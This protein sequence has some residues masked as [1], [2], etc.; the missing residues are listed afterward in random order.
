[1][2]HLVADIG[3]TNSRFA[4]CEVGKTDLISPRK[5]PNKNFASLGDVIAQYLEDSAEDGTP[6]RACLAVAGPAHLDEVKLTNIDWQFSVSEYTK[7]YGFE[8]L[9]LTNDFTALAMSVP[10]LDKANYTCIGRGDAVRIEK[11]PIAVLGPGTGLG[12]S[13]LI[14]NGSSYTALQ[15][16][17]GNTSFA[18]TTDEEL[19]ILKIARLHI[20]H[21]RHEDFISGTGLPFLH[22]I[23]A[24]LHGK[25]DEQLTAEDITW[26]AKMSKGGFCFQTVDVFCGMLGSM[27]GNMA[28]TL[29]AFGG[30]YIGG[31]VAP[32]LEEIFVNSCFRERFEAKGRFKD[33]VKNI[34]TYLLLSHS[35]NAL[36]GAAAMLLPARPE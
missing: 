11:Q 9:R 3:G 12:V 2:F 7:K 36:I 33:Y 17:G 26:R 27:A 29:G 30:V 23:R 20:E 5:Y 25:K 16:E 14:W 13:G 18:P 4:L 24:E 32:Q 28:L 22:K 34:P 31:G 8:S 19:E 1:M 10:Y 35:R 21:V 15:G 6:V